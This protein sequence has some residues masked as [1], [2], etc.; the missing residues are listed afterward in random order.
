MKLVAVRVLN[1]Q[2]IRQLCLPARRQV[3]LDQVRQDEQGIVVEA[4]KEELLVIF[5]LT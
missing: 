2:R 4:L 3:L 1:M 5:V